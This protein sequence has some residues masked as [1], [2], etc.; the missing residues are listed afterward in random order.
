MQLPPVSG[1]G[2][3]GPPAWVPGQ[4]LAGK[5]LAALGEGVYRIAVGAWVLEI[6]S[7]APLGAGQPVQLAVEAGVAGPTLRILTGPDRPGGP[8]APSATLPPAAP[9]EPAPPPT[10]AASP[11]LAGETATR[12]L[13]EAFRLEGLP[14]ERELLAVAREFVSS[15]RSD[16]AA[17]ARTAAFLLAR[18]IAAEGSAAE[19]L[20]AFVGGAPSLPG[21]AE[22]AATLAVARSAGLPELLRLFEHPFVAGRMA[23]GQLGELGPLLVAARAAVAREAQGYLAGNASLALLDRLIERLGGRGTWEARQAHGPSPLLDRVMET[24]SRAIEAGDIAGAQ[25]L[26]EKE[27]QELASE[28]RRELAGRLERLEARLLDSDEKVREFRG[29]FRELDG[30]LAREGGSRLARLALSAGGEPPVYVGSLPA[31]GSEGGRLLVFQRGP[32]RDAREDPSRELTIWLDLTTPSLGRVT[33]LVRLAGE[34]VAVRFGVEKDELARLFEREKGSLE[35]AL[36]RIGLAAAIGVQVD[37]SR[38]ARPAL[39]DS[40]PEGA[41]ERRIDLW[42]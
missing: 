23:L 25:R 11:E 37:E 32:G 29:A 4:V 14:L 18:G 39:F 19:G 5:V 26:V 30:A 40:P 15:S 33:G 13:V 3:T 6:P 35:E 28:G 12:A 7:P 17:A 41:E 21:A 27:A 24:L 1:S 34:G 9:P 22:L 16:P 2:P 38:E 31:P 10:A 42:A 20:A 8:P 36:S